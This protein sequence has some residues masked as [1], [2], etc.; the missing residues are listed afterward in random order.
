MVSLEPFRSLP[1]SQASGAPAG[2]TAYQPDPA[3]RGHELVDA[4]PQRHEP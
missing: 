1:S 4:L 3:Q 2:E